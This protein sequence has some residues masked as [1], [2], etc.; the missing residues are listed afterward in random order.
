MS[1]PE[2]RGVDWKNAC[3]TVVPCFNEATTVA[4]VVRDVQK[5]LPT[6]FVVDDGSTDDTATQ[7]AN[8]G[9][10]LIRNM[11]NRGKGSA[12]RIGLNHARAQGF[13][14][15]LTL[16]GDGQH[17]AT[18]IPDFFACAEKT[19][20]RLVVGNRFGAS[21][22]IPPLRRVVN[23]VMTTLLSRLTQTPLADSQCG[24]RLIDLEAW[25]TLPMTTDHFETESEALVQFIRAGHRVEFVPVQVIYHSHTSKIRP[26]LDTWRWLRWWIIQ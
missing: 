23:R 4:A 3:A 15:A 19:N 26:L 13:A 25:A 1:A 17:M 10:T 2:S 5:Y 22:R 16:D 9:A 8:A 7:S 24:F 6:V 20:A 21:K 12:L 18:D 11:S 14:W